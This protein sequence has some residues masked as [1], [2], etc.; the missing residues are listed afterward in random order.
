MTGA[1]NLIDFLGRD[2]VGFCFIGA[3]WGAKREDGWFSWIFRLVGRQA[4]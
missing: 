2:R 1:K 3:H 4:G